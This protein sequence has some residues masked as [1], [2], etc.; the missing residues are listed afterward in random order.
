MLYS[1]KIAVLRDFMKFYPI[2]TVQ[3]TG[4]ALEE[5]YKSAH[6]VGAVR[7]GTS[8]LFMRSGFRNY[9]IPFHEVRRAFRR[10]ER[11]PARMCCGKGEFEIENLIVCND[12]GEVLK[13]QLP[14][15]KAARLLMEEL[16][17]KIPGAVF[18]CPPK[19]QKEEHLK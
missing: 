1:S 6:A 19:E 5:E 17:E 13:A 8:C 2:G 16:R 12:S 3:D 11:V 9:Y 10:V 15:Q 7:V 14:G 18:G 4:T